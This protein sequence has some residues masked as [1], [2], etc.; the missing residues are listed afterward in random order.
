MPEQ[1]HLDRLVSERLQ[2]L[3]EMLGQLGD[4]LPG[5]WPELRWQWRNFRHLL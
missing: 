4:W 2:R 1:L 5:L 3:P